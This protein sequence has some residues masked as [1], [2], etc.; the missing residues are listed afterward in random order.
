MSES[1]TLSAL[2][3]GPKDLMVMRSLLNLAGGREGGQH[4][5]I[6]EQSGGDVTL[7]DVDHEAG[8]L[9][10]KQMKENGEVAIALSRQKD[11]P[12]RF[13]LNK[14]L[15]SRDF[16]KLLTT[17]AS[18]DFEE[19]T[20]PVELDS[21]SSANESIWETLDMSDE[22]GYYTLA[23]HLRRGSWKKPVA[24][25]HPGWPLLLIDP[26]SGAWFFDGSIAELSPPM[27]AEPM[28]ASAGVPVSSAD[29]VERAQGHRQ[30]PLT[31]LKWFAGLAQ[32]RGRLHPDLAGEVQ[33]ML[34]QVPAQAMSNQQLH[35]LAQVLIR[36]PIT[37]DELRDRS[38]QP[39][40]NVAAFLNACYTS[41]KLLL[42]RM[43]QAASF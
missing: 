30:R 26:G 38:G 17:L 35:Q 33:F 39:P 11:F 4:W 41:G 36:G 31:E 2:H 12:A 22:E 29:L 13:L 28:P 32:S 27:F 5:S 3:V 15:R 25:T 34:T 1:M 16:L 43:A 9:R 8:E 14:P 21:E 6:S 42:N 24:V 23:E 40:E 7:I 37:L 18:G 10:W 19:E 20:V